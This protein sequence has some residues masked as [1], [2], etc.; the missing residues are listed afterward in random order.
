MKNSFAQQLMAA[1][2]RGVEYGLKGMAM[3]AIIAM[4]NVLQDY[5]EEAEK[6]TQILTQVD[7]EIYRIWQEYKTET[8]ALNPDIGEVLVGYYE[9]IL[10]DTKEEP[11]EAGIT[12]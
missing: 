8:L 5:F 3:I 9:R 12:I 1:R 11:H 4:D 2:N 10:R 7:A 6:R